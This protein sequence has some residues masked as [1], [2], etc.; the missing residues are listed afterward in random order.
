MHFYVFYVLWRLRNCPMIHEIL[1]QIIWLCLITKRISGIRV[2]SII[3]RS[4]FDG[5]SFRYPCAIWLKT[6]QEKYQTNVST[7]ISPWWHLIGC[8]PLRGHSVKG[9]GMRDNETSGTKKRLTINISKCT[10]S[11]LKSVKYRV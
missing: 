1:S 5:N 11:P 2:Y 4:S 3:L 7:W 8:W 6:S 10:Y 9:Q